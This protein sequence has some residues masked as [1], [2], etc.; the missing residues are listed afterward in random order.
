[1]LEVDVVGVRQ[2]FIKRRPI[3]IGQVSDVDRI[4]IPAAPKNVSL[5]VAE[6]EYDFAR[7]A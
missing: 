3:L 4:L 7:D 6:L 1:M 5:D 2:Q